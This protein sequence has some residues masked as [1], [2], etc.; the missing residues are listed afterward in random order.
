[1]WAVSPNTICH[2]IPTRHGFVDPP[3]KKQ[4]RKNSDAKREVLEIIHFLHIE[5]IVQHSILMKKNIIS[6][7][8]LLL[9][10]QPE[11]IGPKNSLAQLN[12]YKW[13]APTHL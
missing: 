7:Q 8:V 11:K 6:F 3:Q 13:T 10:F 12:N 2:I 4:N 5:I 1:M 9:F